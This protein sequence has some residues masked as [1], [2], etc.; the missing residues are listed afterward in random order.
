MRAGALAEAEREHL[1]EI[2]ECAAAIRAIVSARW[3]EPARPGGWTRAEIAEHLA[4]SYDPPLSELSGG[5][6]FAVR[7]PW[8]K[9]RFLRWKVLPGIVRGSFPSGAPAP[10]EIR[11]TRTSEGP[12]VAVRRLEENAQ[13]FLTA[14][15]AAGETRDVRLTHPYFGKLSGYEVVK[16]LTAHARHHRKQL[17]G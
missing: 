16:L 2:G 13:R 4:V 14:L 5:P 3:T 10:R 7:L 17:A 12:E 11:P 15:I 8:W 1:E 6:G 9:R